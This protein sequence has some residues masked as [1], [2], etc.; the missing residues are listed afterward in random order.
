MV[1]AKATYKK[2][3]AGKGF[4]ELIEPIAQFS[5]NLLTSI[6]GTPELQQQRT[7]ARIDRRKANIDARN[8]RRKK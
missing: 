7:A 2:N 8:A 5:N 4:E 1:R 6:I 3:Q